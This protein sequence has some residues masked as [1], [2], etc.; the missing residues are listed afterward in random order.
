MKRS[1]RAD[2]ITSGHDIIAME[3]ATFPP[4]TADK[5]AAPALGRVAWGALSAAIA[6]FLF[7]KLADEVMEQETLRFDSAVIHYF[8]H[9]SWHP[10]HLAM[11]AVTVIASGPYQTGLILAMALVFLWK[12]RFWPDGITLLIAGGGGLALEHIL[13]LLFHRTR[14]EPIFY[15]LG[16]SFP[17]GH[18]FFAVVVYGMIAYQLAR[19]RTAAQRAWIYTIASLAIL[20]VGFSRVYLTQHYPTDVIGGYLAGICWLWGCLALPSFIGTR[21]NAP[22]NST[23]SV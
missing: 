14:P 9:H 11:S 18:S 3:Q 12:R 1:V 6:L 7:V 15:H 20:L 22:N 21:R 13:K 19:R 5:K 8:E 4:G 17:S 2:A 16:Y 23:S 10:L